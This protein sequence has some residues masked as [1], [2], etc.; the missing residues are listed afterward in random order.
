MKPRKLQKGDTIGIVCPASAISKTSPRIP[1]M[2]KY[3]INLG[4]NIKYGE[5]F[6]ATYGYLAGDD[7]LRANDL[8]Q[9]FLNPEVSAIICMLGGYGCSRIVDLIDYQIIRNN[10]KL[11]IG[12]SDITVLL[13][14]INQKANIPTVHGV[15]GIY[16]GNPNMDLFSY[17]D[18]EALILEDQKGRVL[19][20]PNSK[21]ETLI[22]GK[23]TGELVGGNLSL[24]NTLIGTPYEIDFTDKI[25]FIEEVDEAP[26]RIDRYFS[27]LR[28]HK[29][30]EKA[31]GFIFGYFTNCNPKEENGWTS[32]DIIKQYIKKLNKPTIY[33]FASGHDF[34]FINLPIGLK[35]E[36]DANKKTIK[37]L[38][39]LY[40]SN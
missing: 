24:I 28:L 34:P 21:C 25:V 15:V 20:S 4:F 10:P 29:M 8:K 7:W 2:E 9:M 1:I 33:N 35:V 23:A 26:Y 16:L 31:K 12:F 6:T 11:F 13:N 5:S 22:E 19:E 17:Q 3:L 39:E 27:T 40:E 30:F 37:I 36:L 14:A 38:E 18:F 32:V